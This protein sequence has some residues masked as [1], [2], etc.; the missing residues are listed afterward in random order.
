MKARF[1]LREASA[2]VRAVPG[3]PG[4]FTCVLHLRPHFQLDQIF[5][6]F[7]LVT[8]VALPHSSPAF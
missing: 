7:K 1:P 6:T 4:A 3:R 2:E 5:T 8:D